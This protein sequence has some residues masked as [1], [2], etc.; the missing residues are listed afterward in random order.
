MDIIKFIYQLLL[1]F[2]LRVK[3]VGGHA[4]TVLR[5]PRFHTE[6]KLKYLTRHTKR[7]GYKC[8]E[9]VGSNF[10]NFFLSSDKVTL[11]CE[12]KLIDVY[13]SSNLNRVKKNMKLLQSVKLMRKESRLIP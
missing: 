9:A 3:S 13:D 4:T 8:V 7:Q 12:A 1:S 6:L 10:Q 2:Y 5:V 11:D